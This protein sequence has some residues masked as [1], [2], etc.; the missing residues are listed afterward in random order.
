M[1]HINDKGKKQRI[2]IKL[3]SALLTDGNGRINDKLLSAVCRQIARLIKDGHE[4]FIVTSGA[5]ACDEKKHRSK[6]LRSAIGQPRIMHKYANFLAKYKIDAAQMLLTDECLLNK[7]N[8]QCNLLKKILNEAFRENI[9]PVINANDV[10]D[11]QEIKALRYCQDNDV[12]LKLVCSLVKADLAIIGIDE[13]GLLD[14]KNKIVCEVNR[15]N[16]REILSF[17]KGGGKLGHGKNGIKTKLK[18]LWELALLGV[19]PILVSGKEKN[20][21]LRAVA[22][23]KNFGTKFIS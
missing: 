6:N 5:I 18:S 11:N 15:E 4:V 21:I 20:F 19:S 22:G 12:M 10:I 23:E 2:G 16:I 9:V 1:P 17:I 8:K 14:Q 7:K 13:K 3:G